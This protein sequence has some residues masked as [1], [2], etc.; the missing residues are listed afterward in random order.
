MTSSKQFP[1]HVVGAEK[2]FMN[3]GMQHERMK[4]KERNEIMT[5]FNTNE[6]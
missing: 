5:V 4:V 6:R 1:I 2:P 3:N